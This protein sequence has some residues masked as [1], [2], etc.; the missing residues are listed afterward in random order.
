MTDEGTGIE[1]LTWIIQ[2]TKKYC[3]SREDIISVGHR[4]SL[5]LFI[6]ERKKKPRET[7]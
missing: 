7:Q 2:R 5:G 4:A 3:N 1:I 6:V